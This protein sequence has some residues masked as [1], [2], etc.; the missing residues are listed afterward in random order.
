LTRDYYA[1]VTSPDQA[2]SESEHEDEPV[3]ASAAMIADTSN[4]ID[5]VEAGDWEEGEAGPSNG[6]LDG[7][8]N[9]DGTKRRRRGA[10]TKEGPTV[11]R[12][13][14]PVMKAIREAKAKE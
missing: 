12:L 14:K 11:Y 6:S 1:H 9:A 7:A 3:A 10:A 8:S 13:I 2:H 5:G 4:E